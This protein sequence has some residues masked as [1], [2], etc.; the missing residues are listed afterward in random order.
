MLSF[1][2]KWMSYI[3]IETGEKAREMRKGAFL[4]TVTA[5]LVFVAVFFKELFLLRAV[6][7]G[8]IGLKVSFF[9]AL[10]SYKLFTTISK[11]KM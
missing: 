10:Y 3:E 8:A 2:T 5:P 1:R 6:L 7:D 11:K 9:R 4:Y